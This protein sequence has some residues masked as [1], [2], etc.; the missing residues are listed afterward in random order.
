VRYGSN[1]E[2]RFKMPRV[3]ASELERENAELQS[4]IDGVYEQIQ[5]ALDPSLTREEVVEKLQEIEEDLAPDEEGEE[6]GNEQGE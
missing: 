3:R 4:T 1:D 5:G 2:R 6:T